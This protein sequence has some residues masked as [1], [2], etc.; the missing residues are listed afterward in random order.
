MSEKNLIWGEA[1]IRACIQSPR[2]RF[3][4]VLRGEEAAHS[5]EDSKAPAA[6]ISVKRVGSALLAVPEHFKSLRHHLVRADPLETGVV[7]VAR[8][9][10]VIVCGETR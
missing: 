8:G 6:P 5:I 3:I 2:E 1:G 7:A 4:C 9:V 10:T